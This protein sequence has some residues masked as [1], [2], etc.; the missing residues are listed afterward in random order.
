MD[1]FGPGPR[2]RVAVSSC[3]LGAPVRYNGGHSR[4]R[5]LTD[6]LDRHVDWVPV[7]P[8]AEIGLGVPRETLRL[9]RT[10]AGT[11]VVASRS[12]AD[13]TDDLRAVADRHLARLRD[14]D[15]YV[16]KNK[17]PS[18]GLFALPVFA[19]GQRVDG[20]GRGAFAER[21]VELLPLLPVEEQGRLTDPGLREH[22]VE[23]VFAH[24]RLRALLAPGW[25]PRD[26]VAFHARHKVQLMAHSP[27]G[28]RE[29]GR[30]VADAGARPRAEVAADYAA[31][32][33]RT[34]GLVA[35]PGRHVNALQH[36]FG[37]VSPHLDAT[38][39]HDVLDAIERYRTGR[40]PLSVP[41][42]LIRHHCAGER[43]EWACA[44]T[45]LDPY[46]DDL[47]LRNTVPAPA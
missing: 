34:L 22:F 12:G 5:F 38:R 13:H 42:A 9:E 45:Y 20:R 2:P 33:Q 27:D 21:L 1:S 15:G 24:A 11:R 14:A 43:V 39:R 31:S 36:L 35:T 17:S 40:V 23:R 32:F 19:G 16:L 8:E 10:G 44:Q 28:Y 47:R 3:L 6:E 46:P 41:V 18:C 25:R 30:I 26:L 29:A 7:C 37:M 4:Y